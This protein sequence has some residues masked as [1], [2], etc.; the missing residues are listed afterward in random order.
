M[1]KTLFDT[2]DDWGAE[3]SPCGLYRYKLWRHVGDSKTTANFICLNPS[4]ADAGTNDPTVTR[5]IERTKRMGHGTLV[6]TNLFA[7][8]ATDPDDM[9]AAPDPIGPY[10]DEWIIREAKAATIVICG[11]GPC[12]LYRGRSVEILRVLSAAGVETHCLALTASREPIH[13]LYQSYDEQP[14]KF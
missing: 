12:G 8:R 1:P 4:K 5:L 3:I 13:P 7:W 14:V 9:M 11:W 2:Q 10:N 6:V